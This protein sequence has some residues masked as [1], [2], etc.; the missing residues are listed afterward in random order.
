MDENLVKI[1]DMVHF[2]SFDDHSL[3]TRVVLQKI[4]TLRVPAVTTQRLCLEEMHR[5]T[6]HSM[7]CVI[8]ETFY[9]T[10][11]SLRHFVFGAHRIAENL[12]PQLVSN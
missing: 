11:L 1:M 12:L 10:L 7:L 9:E 5:E 4:E 6:K 3:S 2:I 8:Y